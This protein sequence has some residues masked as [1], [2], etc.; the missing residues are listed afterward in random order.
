MS[1]GCNQF[2]GGSRCAIFDHRHRR[3]K[4]VAPYR[5]RR[6][7][8]GKPSVGRA[9]RALTVRARVARK[10]RSRACE[11][12]KRSRLVEADEM[13][14]RCRKS[15]RELYARTRKNFQLEF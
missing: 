12:S 3:R 4:R 1:L 2:L 15:E 13:F 7:L 8:R 10:T 9:W 11:R 6:G 14:G 5:R